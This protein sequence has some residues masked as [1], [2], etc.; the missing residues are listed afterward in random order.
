VKKEFTLN[1]GIQEL[2][3]LWRVEVLLKTPNGKATTLDSGF[4][5]TSQPEAEN[6]LQK[7]MD[8]ILSSFVEQGVEVLSKNGVLHQ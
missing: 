1:G 4:V 3:G 7:K 6:A 2:N 5:Y 8:E